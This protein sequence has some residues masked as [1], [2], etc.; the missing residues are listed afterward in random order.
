MKNKK[1]YCSILLTAAL[2]IGVINPTNILTEAAEI[3]LNKASITLDI[4]KT[5]TLKVKGIKKKAKWVSSNKKIATVTQKGKVTAK[6]AGTAKITAKIAKKKYSCTVKVNNLGTENPAPVPTVAPTQEPAPT[7]VPTQ[8]PT[9]SPTQEPTEPTVSSNFEK[10]KA[11]IQSNGSVNES[12]YQSVAYTYLGAEY[13]I[14]FM[15]IEGMPVFSFQSV[16]E[17]KDGVF[18]GISFMSLSPSLPTATCNA[19]L[20]MQADFSYCYNVNTSIDP[21]T[22]TE[23][24]MLAFE[25]EDDTIGLD[26]AT[27]Q[28]FENQRLSNAFVAW[29]LFL[30]KEVGLKWK[31]LG[32]TAY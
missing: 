26:D 19:V 22:Y 18:W 3:K 7:T 10:L 30:N 2:I 21:Q 20:Y 15:E 11:Y 27:I 28:K 16:F 24:T 1:I 25:I 4:G 32:F 9:T 17:D 14:D 6:S 23:D 12:G 8:K 5:F 29:E 31:D 13:R